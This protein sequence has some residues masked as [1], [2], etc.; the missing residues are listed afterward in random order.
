V[1]WFGTALGAKGI[2]YL[3]GQA[4]ESGYPIKYL[5]Y[6]GG[7]PVTVATVPGALSGNLSVSPDE[8]FLL[9]DQLD[10]SGSDLMLVEG[11]R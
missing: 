8:R 4:T 3:V 2:Y 7:K 5:P 6:A 10:Q 9:Y 11:F 1:C